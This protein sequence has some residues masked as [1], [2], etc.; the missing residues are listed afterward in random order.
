[1]PRESHK[2][3]QSPN[4]GPRRQGNCRANTRAVT[5]FIEGH[6][7]GSLWHSGTLPL[8]NLNVAGSTER[9]EGVSW[10]SPRVAYHLNPRGEMGTQNG[11]N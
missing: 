10:G 7:E 3:T 8:G 1:M 11:N 9:R 2:A 5:A 4:F 6:G